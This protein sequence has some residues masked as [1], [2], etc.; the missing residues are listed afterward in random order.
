[1]YYVN[2]YL[3][4]ILCILKLYEVFRFLVAEQYSDEVFKS[5]ME[6][7]KL[8]L[9]WIVYVHYRNV[10]DASVNNILTN[11]RFMTRKGDKK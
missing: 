1:M 10:R 11:E 2:V 7:M 5:C 6:T 8:I 3:R 4:N 9:K